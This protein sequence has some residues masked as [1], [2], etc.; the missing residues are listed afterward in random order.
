MIWHGVSAVILRIVSEASR[1][2]P[3]G[4]AQL[5]APGFPNPTP[6]NRGPA[7]TLPGWPRNPNSQPFSWSTAG[8]DENCPAEGR[9]GQGGETGTL[10]GRPAFCPPGGVRPNPA[11][12]GAWGGGAYALAAGPSR[13]RGSDAL[14]AHVGRGEP[15][16]RQGSDAGAGR[17]TEGSGEG[18]AAAT[19]PSTCGLP[20]TPLSIAQISAPQRHAILFPENL[21]AL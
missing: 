7:H 21:T 11:P 14:V 20:S 10:S 19:D 6:S 2:G 8:I 12:C 4:A 5:G 17:E 9:M 16:T 15:S 3:I 18:H 1:G 13:P